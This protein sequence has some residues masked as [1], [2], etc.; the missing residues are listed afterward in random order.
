METSARTACEPQ[1]LSPLQLHTICCLGP[2]ATTAPRWFARRIQSGIQLPAVLE[3]SAL[4]QEHV[5]ELACSRDSLN[6][7]YV[8]CSHTH[9]RASGINLYFRACPAALLGILLP[10]LSA[11]P[12]KM[13]Q[14][15][16]LLFL[17][18]VTPG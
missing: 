17:F 16:K 2:R 3:R 9:A 5:S 14:C 12:V 11:V 18:P 6:S 1:L 8:H 7:E 4:P 10:G 15:N 13:A